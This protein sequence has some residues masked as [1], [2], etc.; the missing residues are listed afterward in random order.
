M[1]ESVPM[2]SLFR[3]TFI[4]TGGSW[5]Q[6]GRAMPSVMIQ[7][8]DSVSL[9]DCGEGTQKQIM[10]S[11]TSFMKIDHIFISHFHGDH[12]LGILGLIQSMSF[13]GREKDLNVYGP[14][15]AISVLT[16]AFNVGYYS[17][18]YNIRIHELQYDSVVNMD[19]FSVR[20]MKADHPVPALSYRIDEDNLVKI[21][22]EK[23]KNF[24]I[25]S[26]NIETIRNKGFLELNGRKITLEEIQGG[27]RR[28]RSVV[29]SGDTRPNPNMIQFAKNCDILIHDTT[30]DSGLEPKVNEFGHTSSKQ[31]AEIAKN[32]SVGKLFLYHFSPRIDNVQI[33][34]KEAREIFP[35][36]YLSEDLKVI[37]IQKGEV[38]KE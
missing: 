4:G 26:K 29:Y 10:A 6:P 17:L 31:A 16:R 5:P 34:L 35:E 23:A 28:G 22:P 13:N 7:I 32:A 15:G 18:N 14:P 8:D 25:D 9:F 24:G 2:A 1:I 21:D 27:I 12:F 38:I 11:P 19:G 3:I 33:L 30:T 37:E 20:T 36:S